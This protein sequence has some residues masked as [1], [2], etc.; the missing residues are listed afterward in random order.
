MTAVGE[1]I[2][3]RVPFKIR[4]RGGRKL[5]PTPDG[6]LMASTPSVD[7]A[8]IKALAR[9]FRWRRLLEDGS[10][11]TMEELAAAEGINASY[12]SRVLRLTILAPD[13]VK[14]IMDGTHA[15]AVTLAV[16]MKPFDVIWKRQD[17][18][19]YGRKFALALPP[20]A[21]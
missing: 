6:L 19:R 12:V 4:R 3:I 7:N 9:A 21:A 11:R 15:S 14:S 16:L 17:C 18:L 5:V 20:T 1:T 8:M 10:Y 2:T 13:I